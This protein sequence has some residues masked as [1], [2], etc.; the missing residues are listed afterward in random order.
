MNNSKMYPPKAGIKMQKEKK[1]LLQ[2]AQNANRKTPTTTLFGLGSLVMVLGMLFLIMYSSALAQTNAEVANAI[3]QLDSGNIAQV[4]QQ[5]PGLTTKYQND[6]GVIYLQGRLTSGGNE[7]KQYY[8]TIVTNF[9]Q[10]EWADDALYRLYQYNYAMGLYRSANAL[11]QQ[12][13][14]EYP[15][16][17][18]VKLIPPSSPPQTGKTPANESTVPPVKNNEIKPE[19]RRKSNQTMLPSS[20]DRYAYSGGILKPRQMRVK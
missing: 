16:S 18:Y 13:A 1:Y 9:P 20:L 6:P 4:R 11:L 15:A 10:S 19:N 17:P 7:A 2:Y 5:L 14:K 8:Q 12:L 3:A